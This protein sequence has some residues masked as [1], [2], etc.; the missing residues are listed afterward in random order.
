MKMRYVLTAIVSLCLLWALMMPVS[1]LA[2]GNL[3]AN[4]DLEMGN[5]NSWEISDAAIDG[6]VKYGGNYSLKLTATSAYSGA[7]Y[8]TIPVRKNATVT[9]S[10]YYRYAEDPSGK[11]YHVYTYKGDNPWTGA[12][13]NAEASFAATSANYTQW[14]QASYSF[15]SGDYEAVYLK[16]CPGGNGSVSCYIDDLVVT[17]VGGDESETAPYLTS[18]GTK[19]NRPQNAADNLIVNG[20]FESENNAQWNTATFIKGNLSVVADPTAPE[21]DNVLYFDSGTA[22][23][24]VWHTFSVTVEKYTQY[25]FSAW[26]KSPRLSGTNRATATFGV[27]DSANQFLVYEPYNGNGHGAASLSTATMQLMAT[28]PDDEWHLRSVTFNSGSHTTFYI[29]VYGAESQL[30]L[31]DI[32]LFK[33]AYGVEYISDLRTATITAA[34]NH[35]NQYCADDQSL[36][37]D[38]NMIGEAAQRYWSANPAWRNGFLSFAEA[39]DDHDAVL[40]Y[41]ASAYTDRQLWYIDWIDVLPNTDYTLTLDV[42]RLTAGGGRI[43]LL[44][45]NILY[46]AEFYSIPF[47]AVDSAWQTYSVTFNS[48]VYS[49]IGFAVVD[50]GGTAYMDKVRLFKN[51]DGIAE[52]PTDTPQPVLQPCGGQTSSMEMANVSNLIVNGDFESGSLAGFDVYQSTALFE[53]AAYSGAYGAHL[54]GDGSWGALLEQ[55]SIPVEEGKTYVLSFW[56]KANAGGTNITLFGSSTNTQYAYIWAAAGEWTQ[57][58]ATFTPVGDTTVWFNACGAG[59]GIAEDVYLD[60]IGLVCADDMRFG[61]AFLMTL[62]AQGVQWDNQSKGVLTHATV[63]VYGDGARYSLKRMGALMTNDAAVGENLSTFKL[64]SSA[65]ETRKIVDIPAVYLWS[66]DADEVSFAVRVI[67]VPWN[68]LD[69]PIYARPYYVFEKDGE[70][71]VVYGN[72]YNRSY[73]YTN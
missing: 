35:G 22:T 8:K 23:A 10:F 66:V 51:A 39:G 25:T 71:I 28:S 36:I 45:D 11:L 64:D 7:A 53:G 14:K 69:T 1:V 54:K 47:S 32:A 16:F 15:N 58:T 30:Y 2:D 49:R 24:A 21:G 34:A 42:K 37:P 43:A 9:V 70:E 67:N 62:D 52:E 13:S 56:Y 18:Y 41:T 48:G 60:D 27:M 72:V 63:D 33:S 44:D 50:G 38:P 12:Y 55:K 65:I 46:P 29:G 73:N 59:N 68:H 26:V 40:Q 3:A 57:F 5:T 61:V 31:D 20:G 19:Y 6:A 17:S 4:G